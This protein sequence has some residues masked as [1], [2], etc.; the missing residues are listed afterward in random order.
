MSRVS[1]RN[2]E[3]DTPASLLLAL[4]DSHPDRDTWLASFQ[5]EKEGLQNVD[6]FIKIN[7]EEYRQLRKEG[8]P[9]AIPTMCVLTTK[10]D[11]D[12][13]PERAK[14]RIVALGNLE[15]R[16]WAKHERYAPVLQYSSLRLMASLA[17][18]RKRVLQ[19]GDVKH[20][21]CNADLPPDEV[22]IVRPPT[23]DPDAK[24]GE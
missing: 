5:E 1:A 19:Q 14:S 23:G 20:A 10:K 11:K 9:K 6:T 21:F 4:H 3:R 16:E 22:T 13:N 18:Q 2:L 12:F 15:D 8:A 24:P 7:L 17:I